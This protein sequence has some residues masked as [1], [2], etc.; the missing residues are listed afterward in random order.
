[1]VTGKYA[2]AVS[3]TMVAACTYVNVDVDI[4]AYIVTDARAVKRKSVA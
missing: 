2:Q 4:W 1:M 3:P